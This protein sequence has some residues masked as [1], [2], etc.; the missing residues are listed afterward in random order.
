MNKKFKQTAAI[1][2][3]CTA[4]LIVFTL[5]LTAF[6][7]PTQA[8]DAVTVTIF[9]TNDV[10][11]AVTGS[12]SCIGLDRVAAIKA[13]AEINGENPILVDAGDATQ[14]L[15]IASLTKGADIIDIMNIAGYDLMA[16]G[17][18]EFDF[19]TAQALSNASR[20]S[21]PILS[22][23]IYKDD[24]PLFQ[25]TTNNGCH[26]IIEK[27]GKKIGFFALITTE[28]ATATN[29]AGITDLTF[30]DEIASAKTEIQELQAADCDAIIAV[31]HL[32]EYS[33][34]PCTSE[35][36]A[37]AINKEFPGALDVIID[38]HSHTKE[39]KIVN[40]ITIVQTGTGL[41]DLGKLTLTFDPEGNL[42]VQSSPITCEE[43]QSVTPNPD[44]AAKIAEVN[45]SQEP[46]LSTPAGTVTNSLWGGYINYI[47]EARM[48]ETNLGDLT[49]D[50]FRY[51]AKD[52]IE[53][54]P[55]TD[56]WQDV[57]VIAME[58]GG[59]IRASWMNGTLTR[60]DLMNAFPFSNTLVIKEITP[61]ILY[62]IL[63]QS[64][65]SITGQDSSTGMLQGE[66]DG[67]F[68]QVSGIRFSY[69]PTAASGSKINNLSLTDSNTSLDRNDTE[70]RMVLVANN[71]IMNGGN[72]YSMLA[73]LPQIGEIGGELETVESYV[74]QLTEGG[75]IP[76][77][78]PMN[79]NR[80]TITGDTSPAS[81]T[82]TI[83][84]T[85]DGV[86]AANTEVSYYLDNG[87]PVWAT[88]DSEGKLI[89]SVSKGPHGLAL[90]K[91]QEQ[92][93][94]NNYTGAG[95][96]DI[97]DERVYPSLEYQTPAKKPEESSESSEKAPEEATAAPS[98]DMPEETTTATSEKAKKQSQSAST[99]TNSAQTDDDNPWA[100]W[101]SVLLL[102]SISAC[103][104]L[105]KR[106][107]S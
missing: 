33:N 49:A 103:T 96:I 91:E 36:L 107:H 100:L 55:G 76:L 89:I 88:T 97:T 39:D 95:V 20:A 23:N 63:E 57:P 21:F 60:G 18:H 64:V 102:S 51:A 12:S 82:A 58:N 17:N 69:D 106:H 47:A 19:G 71:Y 56:A 92:V 79:Q 86:P 29:P 85:K 84:I 42:T 25:T 53:H 75:T 87:D 81:Y 40:D 24:A 41:T 67:G 15:P 7:L 37:N 52:F 104:I 98:E 61:S 54:A 2:K 14:G 28:T 90:S 30:K 83:L 93:Y 66:P 50:A 44:T 11:G 1:R 26:T 22:A 4:F 35:D 46:L 65:S 27:A 5:F 31:A 78:V 101:I 43:A 73:P 8:A 99:A 16:A 38:G 59:G 77:D 68:A 62:Q 9:H 94:L 34:V 72:N 45:R 3:K 6:P 13:N 74:N 48:V 10:H 80:I 105:S 32:G 70:T